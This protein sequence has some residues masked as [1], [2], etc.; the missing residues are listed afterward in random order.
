MGLHGLL[1][2]FLRLHGCVHCGSGL[3]RADVWG[4]KQSKFSLHGDSGSEQTGSRRR[5][6]TRS[7]NSELGEELG[8]SAPVGREAGGT[9]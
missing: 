4:G 7:L 2:A 9:G 1:V 5:P 8:R 6:S 3:A